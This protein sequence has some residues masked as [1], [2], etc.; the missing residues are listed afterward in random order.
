MERR[1]AVQPEKRNL[2]QQVYGTFHLSGTEYAVEMSDLQEVVTVPSTLQ[3]MPLAPN[4]LLGLFNL[5]GQVIPVI[6]LSVL[7]GCS[8]ERTQDVQGKRLA[9]LRDANARL[10]LLFDSVGEIL[11]MQLSEVSPIDQRNLS[12]DVPK[13]PV[14]AI[15]CR[16]NGKRLIQVLDLS[17]ILCVRNLP[18]INQQTSTEDANYHFTARMQDLYREKLIGFSVGECLL[19]LEMKCVVAIVQNQAKAPSPRISDLCGE[20]V[21]FQGRT[22]P[23]IRMNRLLRVAP[24]V[25]ECA[26]I[27]ICR[28]GTDCIGLE[29]D[30]TNSIIPYAKE[31]VVPVPVLDD[32]RSEIFRGCFTDREGRDFIVLN[33][34]GILSKDEILSISLDH[35]KLIEQA[36]EGSQSPTTVARVPLLTFKMGKVYGIRLKDVLEVKTCPRDLARAPDTPPAVLG[37]LN[38]RGTPVSVV[39]PKQLFHLPS[40]EETGSDS[41]LLLFQHQSRKVGMR[42]DSIESIVHVS[43][44]T[45]DNLPSIFFSEDRPLLQETFERGVHLSANGEQ[46]AV[47]VLSADQVVDRLAMALSSPHNLL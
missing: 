3:S 41:Y 42:V 47:L 38:L 39:D 30:A 40:G 43:I 2:L 31:R 20:V 21:N 11:R 37:V 7:L 9:V 28:I 33:E 1:I 6:D 34:E 35:R 22:L 13:M 23:V 4:Y 5:R 14:K 19:A 46:H 15:I 44:G 12:P 27:L 32:Y 10:G 45:E 26:H 16:D 17:A 8:K 18:I 29:V 24:V 25:T 36:E